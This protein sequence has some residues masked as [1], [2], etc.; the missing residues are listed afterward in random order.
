MP[1]FEHDGM[2]LHFAVRGPDDGAPLIVLHGLGGSIAQIDRIFAP[3]A[4]AGVRLIVPDLRGH[5]LSPL[6]VEDRLSF[7]TLAGD[8]RAL[9]MHLR[10][11]RCTIGGISMGA[12][13]ALRFALSYPELAAGLILVRPAWLDGPMEESN[14]RLFA[15]IARLIREHGREQGR[16][17]FV[18]SEIYARLSGPS[19]GAV[20]R[21]MLAYFDNERADDMAV[22]FTRLP[23]DAPSGSRGEWRHI[24][25]PALVL[26]N[27]DDPVHPYEYGAVYAGDMPRAVLCEI[28]A[29]SVSEEQHTADVREH[30]H[31]FM[32]H[33]GEAHVHLE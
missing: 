13:V 2:S 25:C 18:A 8:V 28:T 26:V 17:R 5:G 29:K 9:M 14:R 22:A 23:A 11:S 21:S 4:P 16:A 33:G 30:I 20:R 24:A 32:D 27:R 7:A 3:P 19:V 12:A 31:L 15:F 6:G 10:L 1:H